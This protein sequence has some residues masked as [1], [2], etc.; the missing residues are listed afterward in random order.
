MRK[1]ER[2]LLTKQIEQSVLANEDNDAKSK[3]RKETVD[4]EVEALQKELDCLQQIWVT[5]KDELVKG[6]K[7]QEKLDQQGES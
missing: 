4:S 3:A 7:L 6:K 1:V 5:G 2:D